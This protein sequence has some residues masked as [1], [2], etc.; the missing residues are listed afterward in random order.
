MIV[1]E[2]VDP[3]LYSRLMEKNLL[4][5]YDFLTNC[6]EIGIIQGP[7]SFDKYVL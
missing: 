3:D 6:I 1:F 2:E 7:T 5:Q 4:R